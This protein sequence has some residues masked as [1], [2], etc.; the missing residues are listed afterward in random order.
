MAK[1]LTSEDIVPHLAR[2][3]P[4]DLALLQGNLSRRT[5]ET[6][7]A[8]A[9]AR[10][11][12]TVLNAAPIAFAYDGLWQHVAV[13]VV[14][15]VEA[16]QLGEDEEPVRAAERLRAAGCGAGHRHARRRRRAHRRR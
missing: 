8:E 2:L 13:A 10:G 5:T 3:G 11:A 1:S 14:N 4:S 7:L 16:R 6:V 9:R 12:M 15:G